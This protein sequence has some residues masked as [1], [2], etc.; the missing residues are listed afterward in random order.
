MKRFQ[1]AAPARLRV[2]EVDTALV[3]PQIL[4]LRALAGRSVSLASDLTPWLEGQ[5]MRATHW[6]IFRDAGLIAT[7]RL[8]CHASLDETADARLFHSLEDSLSG[9]VAVMSHCCVHPL[10]WDPRLEG[11]LDEA[12]IERARQLRLSNVLAVSESPRRIAALEAQGFDR[13]ESPYPG[14]VGLVLQFVRKPQAQVVRLRVPS[15]R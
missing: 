13:L 1:A 14:R 9:R 5:D 4:R 12:R 8:C 2:E 7:A 11:A 3:L 15:R 6:G 10:A